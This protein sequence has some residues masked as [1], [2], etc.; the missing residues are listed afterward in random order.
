MKRN[1]KGFT[2]VE[3][4]VVIAILAILATVSIVGYLSFTQKAK[5][6]KA[7][8][9]LVQMRDVLVGTL[10]DSRSTDTVYLDN[11]DGKIVVTLDTETSSE[12]SVIDALVETLGS[13]TSDLELFTYDAITLMD[14]SKTELEYSGTTFNIYNIEYTVDGSSAIWNISDSSVTI[15]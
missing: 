5:E 2:L 12:N 9:E 6:S 14:E 10:L 11:T 4:L 7:Q 1:K 15:A 8:T 3:L 13:D